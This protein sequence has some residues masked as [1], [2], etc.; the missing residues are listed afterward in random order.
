MLLITYYL[1][2]FLLDYKKQFIF[3]CYKRMLSNTYIQFVQDK[4]GIALVFWEVCKSKL[5]FSD[6]DFFL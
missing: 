1:L 2:L 3:V 6:L 5:S 4:N